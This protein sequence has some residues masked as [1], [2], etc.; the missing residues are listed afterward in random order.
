MICSVLSTLCLLIN[1][2]FLTMIPLHKCTTYP[3]QERALS[4]HLSGYSRF[5]LLLFEQL[6]PYRPGDRRYAPLFCP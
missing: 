4:F 1:I 6:R 2:S 5:I 3:I